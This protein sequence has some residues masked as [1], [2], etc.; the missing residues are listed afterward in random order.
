MILVW[1]N[2]NSFNRHLKDMRVFCQAH[3]NGQKW[4][5]KITEDVKTLKDMGLLFD[6][7][8]PHEKGLIRSITDAR[9]KIVFVPIWEMILP[10]GSQN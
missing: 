7:Q 10:R 8:P 6:V 3:K 5:P 9:G 1:N 2:I 4:E